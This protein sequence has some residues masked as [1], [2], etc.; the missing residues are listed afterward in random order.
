MTPFITTADLKQA[1]ADSIHKDITKLHPLWDRLCAD[2]V[3]AGYADI[4][5]R[6]LIKGFTIAQVDAWD[7]GYRYN[8]DQSLF[9]ALTRG[10]AFGENSDRDIAK[11][12]H[13]KELESPFLVAIAV[14]GVMVT[15]GAVAGQG[16]QVAT[17][18]LL[19]QS[20]GTDY[21]TTF[22]LKVRRKDGKNQ[23]GDDIPTW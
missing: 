19:V 17:G 14:G 13:R 2:C 12:D 1:V 11:L 4:K 3:E 16:G 9:W 22:G 23:Y 5:N 15:P 21:G 20:D 7:D 6:L 8:L 10:A 18:S